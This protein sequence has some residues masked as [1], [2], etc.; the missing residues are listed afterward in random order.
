LLRSGRNY[1][2]TLWRFDRI[3]V[4]PSVFKLNKTAHL[5]LGL[6]INT[7]E[8]RQE[9]SMI[10]LDHDIRETKRKIASIEDEKN[11]LVM[12]LLRSYVR[13]TTQKKKK[14]TTRIPDSVVHSRSGVNT[15]VTFSTYVIHWCVILIHFVSTSRKW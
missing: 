13:K 2:Y 7:L 6:Y 12:K 5:R 11:K 14:T 15:G 8:K 3:H 4:I 9:Q 10:K 1:T